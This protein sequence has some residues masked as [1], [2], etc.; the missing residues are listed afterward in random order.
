MDLVA[1]LS[2]FSTGELCWTADD[3]VRHIDAVNRRRGWTAIHSPSD[4]K[5]PPGALL[6]FYLRD[7]DRDADHPRLDIF[8]NQERRAAAKADHQAARE[9]HDRGE[10]CGREWCC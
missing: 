9:L 2:R 6:A 10:R 8:L 7:V 5:N 1:T 4:L 3:V